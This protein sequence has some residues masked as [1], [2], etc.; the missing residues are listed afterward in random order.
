MKHSQFLT[1]ENV[2]RVVNAFVAKG[3]VRK[4]VIQRPLSQMD[5]CFRKQRAARSGPRR[6]SATTTKMR[7][8]SPLCDEGMLSSDGQEPL[9]RAVIG[10]FC[11]RFTPGGVIVSIGGTEARSRQFGGAYLERLGV[12]F[13]PVARMPDV[14]IHD[15]AR[16]WLVLVD[17][18]TCGGPIDGRRRM[19]LKRMF[20][21]FRNGLVFITAV[22]TRRSLRNC[23]E[24]VSW[25]TEVWVAA[26]PGHMLHLNGDRFLGPYPDTRTASD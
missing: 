1:E 12:R 25:E 9:V 7:I 15:N 17:A 10:L 6:H 2:Q 14:V 3:L 13:D 18:A 23:I 20:A 21:G 8:R 16:N 19:E 4:C 24:Q 11:P 26:E 22:E 5:L